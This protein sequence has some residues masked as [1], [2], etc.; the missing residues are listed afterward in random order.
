[1][2]QIP[3]TTNPIFLSKSTSSIHS[4]Y[5]STS[6]QNLDSNNGG[7]SLDELKQV[8]FQLRQ[9]LNDLKLQLEHCE[10][11]NVQLVSDLEECQMRKQTELS[12]MNKDLNTRMKILMDENDHMRKSA[13]C[14]RLKLNDVGSENA[15]LNTNLKDSLNKLEMYENQLNSMQSQA[16]LDNL[17]MKR[18]QHEL[19]NEKVNYLFSVKRYKLISS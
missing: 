15:F 5:E 1:M 3:L 7:E 16:N 8:N 11:A 18:L 10:E 17:E 4:D 12:A 19:T 14:F 2:S 6:S 9:Y 13:E